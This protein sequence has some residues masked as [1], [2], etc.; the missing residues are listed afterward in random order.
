VRDKNTEREKAERI[1]KVDWKSLPVAAHAHQ[2]FSST[3]SPPKPFN[4]L[5]IIAFVPH[6]Q[7]CFVICLH[8][9]L[10]AGCW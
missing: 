7:I 1:G 2:I 5:S 8:Q 6:F 9:L 4:M 10:P 3:F